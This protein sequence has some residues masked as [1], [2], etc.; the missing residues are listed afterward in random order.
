MAFKFSYYSNILALS[1]WSSCSKS[2]N[3]AN[4]GDISWAAELRAESAVK[5]WNLGKESKKS[6]ASLYPSA[7]CCH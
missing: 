2:W 6:D 5:G 3:Y 7:F 4:S 1:I